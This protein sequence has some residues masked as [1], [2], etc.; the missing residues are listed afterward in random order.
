MSVHHNIPIVKLLSHKRHLD[1]KSLYAERDELMAYCKKHKREGVVGKVFTKEG[2][3]FFKEKID[4]PIIKRPARVKPNEIRLP[5]MPLDK[6]ISAIEQAKEEVE[7]NG[8]RFNNPKDAM[9]IVANHLNA[10]AREHNYY[11]KGSLFM[12]YQNYLESKI[13]ND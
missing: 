4:L 13:V 12:Y 11:L 7:R 1:I 3:I 2:G 9:P 10:Q 6:I 5:S 8:G